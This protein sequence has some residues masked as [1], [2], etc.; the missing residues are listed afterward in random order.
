MI[1][2]IPLEE[3]KEISRLDREKM[4]AYEVEPGEVYQIKNR[5]HLKPKR[6]YEEA[7]RYMSKCE[8]PD[9]V[10]LVHGLYKPPKLNRYAGHAWIEIN[11]NVIFDGVLQRF[12]KKTDYIKYYEAIEEMRYTKKEMFSTGLKNGGH[13]GPW[14]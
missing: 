4:K 7:F 5:R 6:C 12:Y 9:K 11:G 14:H 10:V 1:I 8:H 13:Y 3:A 2:D